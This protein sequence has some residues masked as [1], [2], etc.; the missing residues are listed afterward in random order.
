[1]KEW[2]FI[3]KDDAYRYQTYK[4]LMIIAK[5]DWQKKEDFEQ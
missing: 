3:I 2:I 1:M 4:R 5:I